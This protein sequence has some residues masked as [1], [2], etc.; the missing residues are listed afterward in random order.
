VQLG[1]GREERRSGAPARVS[2]QHTREAA[3]Q[4]GWH[5]MAG[6]LRLVAQRRAVLGRLR[7]R[8]GRGRACGLDSSS[9]WLREKG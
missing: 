1:L 9:L 4:H 5:S 6:W 7:P 3:A 8:T 2:P